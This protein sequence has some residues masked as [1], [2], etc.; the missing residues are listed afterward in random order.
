M[1]SSFVLTTIVDE[2]TKPIKF[3]FKGNVDRAFVKSVISA[4]GL[5]TGL[6]ATQINRVVDAQ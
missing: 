3:A 1:L 4:T 2:F 5:A 6:P